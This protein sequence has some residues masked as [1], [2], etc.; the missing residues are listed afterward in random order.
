MTGTAIGMVNSSNSAISEIKSH[1]SPL[2]MME[3]SSI[4]NYVINNASNFSVNEYQHKLS[5]TKL[6]SDPKTATDPEA[7]FEVQKSILDYGL[8]MSLASALSRKVIGAVEG[9]LKT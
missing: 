3:G 7:L 1:M 6:L 4:E 5:T 2:N 9:L 8:Q